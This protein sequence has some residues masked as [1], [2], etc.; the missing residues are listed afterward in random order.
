ML[1]DRPRADCRHLGRGPYHVGVDTPPDP[2][3]SV[4]AP[5]PVAADAAKTMA[6]AGPSTGARVIGFLAILLAGA[7]GAFIGYAVTGLQCH[8]DCVTATGLGG[9]V[10]AVIAA[11]GVAIVVQLALRAMSE[12]RVIE[13]RGGTEAER[14]RQRASER[15]QPPAARPRPRV[16]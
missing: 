12:W 9:L 1:A 11:V 15:R 7:A 13:A 8:D 16:R 3:P 10:G 14:G 2:D 4:T 5:V 6:G